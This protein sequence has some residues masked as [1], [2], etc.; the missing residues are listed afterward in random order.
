MQ[1]PDKELGLVAS[2]ASDFIDNS[3][4]SGVSF[5]FDSISDLIR[6]ERWEQIYAGIRQL[7]DLL[8]VPNATALFLANTN[9]MDPRF[10]SALRGSFALQLRM[11]ID[12]LRAV[13]IPPN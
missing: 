12:G 11:D 10:L 7:I 9:T 6:G 5:V 13:K 8:T 1:I 4:N 3:K 2:I